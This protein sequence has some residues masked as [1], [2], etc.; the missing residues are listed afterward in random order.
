MQTDLN[1]NAIGIKEYVLS[2][3]DV[4][5]IDGPAMFTC[6]GLG[7]CIGVFLEDRNAGVYGGAHIFLPD[8]KQPRH[9]DAG[10]HYNVVQAIDALLEQFARMGSSLQSVSAKI[11]G[12][13]N[14]IVKGGNSI[15]ERNA[16]SAMSY[17]ASRGIK[18][19]SVD[20]GGRESRTA[21]FHTSTGN[22]N[23]NNPGKTGTRII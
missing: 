4:K 12:G 17:L 7:S 22:V 18:I 5:T 15:G 10:K 21:R 16:R 20:V 6:L 19:T 8:N 9:P 14:V 2:I 11:T 1:K 23:I 13:A 3:G